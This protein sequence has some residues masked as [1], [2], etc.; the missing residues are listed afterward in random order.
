MESKISTSTSKQFIQNSL[1]QNIPHRLAASPSLGPRLKSVM[2]AISRRGGERVGEGR[3]WLRERDWGREW[4][5]KREGAVEEESTKREKSGRERLS[6]FVLVFFLSLFYKSLFRGK[7]KTAEKTKHSR[8]GPCVISKDS[9]FKE[10]KHSRQR[11]KKERR[12]RS[13]FTRPRRRPGRR[14]RRRRG[15]RSR[16]PLWRSGFSPAA[17]L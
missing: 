6:F 1:Q 10:E 13:A 11:R 2:A 9:A 15:P 5:W 3:E 4:N 7:G 14:R 17:S 8:A 16:R 12:K